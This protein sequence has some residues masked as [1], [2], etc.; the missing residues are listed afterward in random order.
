MVVVNPVILKQAS[1]NFRM[2]KKARI[3]ESIFV[4]KVATNY[5]VVV[6]PAQFK[7]LFHNFSVPILTSKDKAIPAKQIYSTFSILDLI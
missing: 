6:I 7:E 3:I 5:Q 1:D 4:L 2:A